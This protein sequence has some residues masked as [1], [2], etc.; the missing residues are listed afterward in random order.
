MNEPTN[1]PLYADNRR[2]AGIGCRPYAI[3]V[4]VVC[5]FLAAVPLLMIFLGMISGGAK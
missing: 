5:G 4:A 1:Q 2:N 3:T